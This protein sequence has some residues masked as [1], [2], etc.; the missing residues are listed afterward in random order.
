[1][2]DR[3]LRHFTFRLE[4]DVQ[5]WL[6]QAARAAGFPKTTVAR[7]FLNY[8][9]ACF[10][11]ADGISGYPDKLGEALRATELVP[12]YCEVEQPIGRPIGVKETRPR[13]PKRRARVEPRASAA[14]KHAD[15]GAAKPRKKG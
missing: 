12:L 13:R 10:Y 9:I 11:E 3:E 6:G 7:F 8:G 15:W 4:A 1:M 2:A 5:D 14:S